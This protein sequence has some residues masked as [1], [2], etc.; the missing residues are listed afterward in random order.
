MTSQHQPSHRVESDHEFSL[1]TAP[2]S[3][4]NADDSHGEN[5]RNKQR[6]YVKQGDA[7]A[8]GAAL[9]TRERACLDDVARLGTAS[10][11]QLER[12]HFERTP[13]GRRLAQAE[14]SR[15]AALSVLQRLSRR[16]G[17][18]R[19]GS[20]GYV[21]A[22]GVTGQRIV[23]PNRHRYREPWTPQPSYLRHALTVSE[24]YVRL[25]EAETSG[26][27]RLVTYDAEPRCWRSFAGLGGAMATLKPDAY[28]VLHQGDFEDRL[29]IEVDLATESGPRILKKAKA[30]VGYW[31]SGKEQEASGIFP[32][33]CW[34]TST[35]ERRD[36]LT[37][38][39][40]RLPDAERPLFAVTTTANFINHIAIGEQSD[41]PK[42]VYP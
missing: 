18:V 14:L 7:A 16:I 17:G 4:D 30:Y 33:V 26:N 42:E 25:K 23:Y 15:L 29:F 2:V 13:A 28:A 37:R 12:L 21:Y 10:G 27:L 19:A 40:E 34:V 35:E 1:L 41:P 5:P 8:I 39:L 20:R 11:R 24:L 22:L 6:R 3:A 36:F 38:V 32:L 9:S 31:R